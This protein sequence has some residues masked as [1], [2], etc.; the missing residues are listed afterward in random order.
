MAIHDDA[1]PLH[2]TARDPRTGE[3][4]RA[5]GVVGNRPVWP[6]LGAE[7]N[8]GSGGEG[9]TGS[10][11]GAGGQSGTDSGSGQ[12]GGTGSGST[13]GTGAGEGGQ[14]TGGQTSQQNTGQQPDAQKVEDLPEWAQKVIRDARSDAASNRTKATEAATQHQSLMEKLAEALGVKKDEAPDPEKLAKDLGAAQ[15]QAREAVAELAVYR[16]AGKQNGNADALLDSRKFSAALG[17]LD[18]NADDF[19]A[20]LDALVKETVESDPKFRAGRAPG[21]SG[22]EFTGGTGGG[23]KAKSL[24]DAI[25]A[26]YGSK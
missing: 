13:G 14:Q 20:K 10:G 18:P 5:I 22:A 11:S 6:I 15:G 24:T 23:A 4:L 16:S 21:R 2:P 12:T 8:A 7:D 3:A 1:L 9:G 26:H 25:S 17:K 19:T